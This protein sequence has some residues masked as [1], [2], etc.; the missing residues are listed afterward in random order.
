MR[1][2][3]ARIAELEYR[4][5]F[6][7]SPVAVLKVKEG[8]EILDANPAAERLLEYEGGVRGRALRSLLVDPAVDGPGSGCR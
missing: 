1:I 6:D 5:V 2:V 8:G 7:G 3:E 4:S